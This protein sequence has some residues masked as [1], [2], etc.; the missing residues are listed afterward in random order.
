M[1]LLGP[2]I[3][4]PPMERS[5]WLKAMIRKFKISHRDFLVA[6]DGG[7]EGYSILGKNFLPHIAIGD[8]DSLSGKILKRYESGETLFL[9]LPRRKDASDLACALRAVADLAREGELSRTSE[10]LLVGF[11]GCRPDH[12]LASLLEIASFAVAHGS[13]AR[14]QKVAAIGPEAEYHFLTD[15]QS[16]L[17][18]VRSKGTGV[19]LFTFGKAQGVSLKGF[20]YNLQNAEL[21]AGSHGLS[22]VV[23]GR[24]E[25]SV[26]RGLL[27]AVI[28][29]PKFKSNPQSKS[30]SK[31]VY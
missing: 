7:L 5:T 12:H 15:K 28:P 8:W 22:N 27:L 2:S 10:L 16:S 23:H 30:S 9:T 13:K 21:T 14:F 1:I 6:V 24:A 25:I 26:K 17:R 11:T 18:V 29:N 3:D 31:D 19:S 4:L 20:E